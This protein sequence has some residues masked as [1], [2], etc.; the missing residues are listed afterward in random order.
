VDGEELQHV[1]VQHK[2]KLT[3]LTSSR[4]ASNGYSSPIIHVCCT[5]YE[6]SLRI[7]QSIR[8][9]D[10]GDP[11]VWSLKFAEL[12]VGVKLTSAQAS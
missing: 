4:K 3:A 9:S 6:R 1:A 2:F 8:G 12:C 7:E 11:P 5:L 10:L